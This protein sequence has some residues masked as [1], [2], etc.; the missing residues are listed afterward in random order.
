VPTEQADCFCLVA[1]VPC[2]AIQKERPDAHRGGDGDEFPVVPDSLPGHEAPFQRLNVKRP[3][4]L[5]VEYVALNSWSVAMAE[6]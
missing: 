1:D 2:A 6:K 5:L 4:S 3:S